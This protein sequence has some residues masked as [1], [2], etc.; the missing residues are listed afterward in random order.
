MLWQSSSGSDT[1]ISNRS[2][3]IWCAPPPFFYTESPLP[4]PPPPPGTL[5]N[6]AKPPHPKFYQ[7]N[8]WGFSVGIWGFF[9]VRFAGFFFGK[10]W[11][12]LGVS[13]SLGDFLGKVC[14]FFLVDFGVTEPF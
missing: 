14:G 5:P 7:Q 3:L 12:C 13:L 8:P 6:L 1:Q 4:P 2:R 10:N 9:S 11:G